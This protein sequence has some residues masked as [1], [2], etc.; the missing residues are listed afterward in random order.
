MNNNSDAIKTIAAEIKRCV[1]TIIKNASYDRTVKG[2]IVN[3]LGGKLYEVQ[4]CGEKYK[5]YSPMFTCAVNDIVYIKIAENNY[6]N[7][8]IEY[9]INK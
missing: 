8:I 7:L 1:D 3:Y 6:N 9:P 5:A 4:I 2:M